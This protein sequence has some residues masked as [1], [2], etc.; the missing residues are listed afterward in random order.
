[1]LSP[2][3]GTKRFASC[4]LQSQPNARYMISRLGMADRVAALLTVCTPHR[5]SQYA[6]WCLLNLGKRMGGL[7]LMKLLNLDIQALTDL[8]T[9][10]CAEFNEKITDAPDVQY[11][12]V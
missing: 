9:T 1:M 10:S 7:R 8:T 12:S 5:G 6:D 2:A 11:F 4:S 3:P